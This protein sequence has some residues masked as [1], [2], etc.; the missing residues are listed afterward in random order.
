[1]TFQTFIQQYRPQL[2]SA[3]ISYFEEKQKEPVPLLFFTD[4]LGRLAQFVPNGKMLRGLFILLIADL[5]GSSKDQNRSDILWVA[6]AMEIVQ[7]AFLIHDDIMDNDHTRRGA[8]T[9]FAQYE[10]LGTK[11]QIH[12]AE[13]YGK[14]M[15]I[16]IGDVAFFLAFELIQRIHA[17]KEAPEIIRTFIQD[18]SIVSAAQMTDMHYGLSHEEPTPKQIR[19]MYMYKTAHYSFSLPLHLGALYSQA[20]KEDCNKLRLLGSYIGLTFQIKDDE[21]KLMGSEDEVGTGIGSDIR[22]NKKTLIRAWLLEEADEKDTTM[23]HTLFGKQDI[24]KEEIKQ[25]RSLVKK[26]DIPAYIEQETRR[27]T[28]KASEIIESLTLP[29]KSKKR[30]N[31]M[32]SYVITRKK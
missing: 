16:C 29:S 2:E 19:T 12:N 5:Y 27:L 17:R 24:S 31:D 14:S 8:P 23:L 22:E 25:V 11:N 32:I 9:I 18:I 20:P 3:L 28:K 26:Y 1:M 13:H 30:L 21:L 10:S 15:G 6:A 4:L 7:S